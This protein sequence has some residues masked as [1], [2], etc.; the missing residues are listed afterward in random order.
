MV[1]N[2][3]YDSDNYVI[4]SLNCVNESLLFCIVLRIL[5]IKNK[6]H[7]NSLTRMIVKKMKSKKTPKKQV[8]IKNQKKTLL[9]P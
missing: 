5:I 7:E 4:D 6:H 3:M 9:R 2:F 1:F 8:L